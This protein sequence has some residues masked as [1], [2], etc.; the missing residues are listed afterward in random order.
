MSD[1]KY[2]VLC[3]MYY[4]KSVRHENMASLRV[5]DYII[6]IQREEVSKEFLDIQYHYRCILIFK[7]LLGRELRRLVMNEAQAGVLIDNISTF[8]YNNY[9]QLIALSNLNGP[10][11][12]EYYNISLEAS[13]NQQ[14]DF[15]TLFRVLRYNSVIQMMEPVL[16]IE[17]ELQE[18]D[19]LCSMMFFV[20][21]IDLESEREGI[22]KV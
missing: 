17:L 14:G 8:I 12:F 21:L 16:N 19:D 13:E 18:L 15:T 6:E 10:T 2:S 5:K 1:S 3:N 7:D 11:V 4:Q 9:N 20:Y 22:Y